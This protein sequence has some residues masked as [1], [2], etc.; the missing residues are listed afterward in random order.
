MGDKDTIG[1][2]HPTKREYGYYI[3]DYLNF[4]L[5]VITHIYLILMTNFFRFA[6]RL[7]NDTRIV[8]FT[9]K[10]VNVPIDYS[11]RRN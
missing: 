1:L 11:V 4:K 10:I 6:R 8:L 7:L 5:N 3:F 2:S 9:R